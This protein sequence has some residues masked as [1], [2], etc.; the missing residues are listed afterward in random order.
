MNIK[1]PDCRETWNKLTWVIWYSKLLLI[2][3]SVTMKEKKKMWA[4][5]ETRILTHPRANRRWRWRDYNEK[6]GE[7]MKGR[8]RL[9][10]IKSRM[11]S[12]DWIDLFKT[13]WTDQLEK[14]DFGLI[15][16]VVAVLI[17]LFEWDR[18][19]GW[20]ETDHWGDHS[21][22]VRRGTVLAFTSLESS[23]ISVK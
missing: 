13:S 9:L 5:F 15:V 1:L 21:S 3:E 17:W 2:E 7:E 6:E 14:T 18:G 10:I 20:C 23:S 19:E 8:D 4:E 16:V 11:L 12:S 22:E